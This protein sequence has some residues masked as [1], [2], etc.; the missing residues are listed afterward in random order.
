MAT[1]K[2]FNTVTEKNERGTYKTKLE[3]L[4]KWRFFHKTRMEDMFLE[5]G[6][7][8]VIRKTK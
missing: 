2:I 5:I 1:Y 7:N 3:A 4:K 8:F 6:T